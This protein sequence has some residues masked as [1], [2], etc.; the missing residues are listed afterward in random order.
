MS[1]LDVVDSC[2]GHLVWFDPCRLLTPRLIRTLARR[3]VAVCILQ[4]RFALLWLVCIALRGRR[5]GNLLNPSH[6]HNSLALLLFFLPLPHPGRLS[7]HLHYLFVLSSPPL[8]HNHRSPPVITAVMVTAFG[9]WVSRS[10]CS[11]S[12]FSLFAMTGAALALVLT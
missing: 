1:T 5:S 2:V 3:K 12:L 9:R 11:S 7:S 6:K 4:R 10:R 8:L